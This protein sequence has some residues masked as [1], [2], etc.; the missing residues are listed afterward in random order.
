MST[1]P[2]VL[3]H[4]SACV[5]DASDLGPGTRVWHFS[6]VMRG[7]RV[8]ASCVLGQNVFVAAGARIGD[9]VRI[10]NNVSVYDGVVVEDD[11]FLGPSC[12]LT[13]V[14]NPRAGISRHGRFEP[15]LIRRGAT[16]GANATIVC[17]VT[18]GRHALVAAGAVVTR[19]VPDYAL[20]QGVPA[21]RAGWFGRHGERL[22]EAADGWRC[23]VSGFRYGASGEG[24]RCLDL[25]EDA[26]LPRG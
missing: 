24:L 6:H 19:D 20:V 1:E 15:T 13:N 4:P 3:V 17:G 10:Q 22:V 9:R 23:P 8:G 2:T 26:P 16:L 18:V 12:V 5:D 21:R 11:A 25:D 7:A 14:S